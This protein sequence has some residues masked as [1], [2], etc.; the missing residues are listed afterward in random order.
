M[1]TETVPLHGHLTMGVLW[2]AT[3]ALDAARDSLNSLFGPVREKSE[4][5]P[6]D[7]YTR[8]YEREMGLGISRC[9]WVFADPFPLGGL[10]EAKLATNRVERVCSSE[11]N[12]WINLDPGL[13]TLYSLVLATTKP[14]YHRI[15]LS[16]GIYAELALV[17]KGG[18]TE[19]LPWTYPDYRDAW[20][21]EFFL[22]ARNSMKQRL[23]EMA[24]DNQA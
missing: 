1:G 21:M 9:F 4:T 19:P 15:Y 8:Y 18:R 22:G 2:S 13:L 7:G 11:G 5:V 6:F 3:G 20:A 12:R 17:F 10:Q 24:N 23:G 16:K 14:Y